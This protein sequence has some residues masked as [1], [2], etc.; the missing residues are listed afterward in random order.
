MTCTSCSY[1]N[2]D[3]SSF[4]M[5]CGAPLPAAQKGAAQEGAA[6]AA[7]P[8]P[9]PRPETLLNPYSD[10]PAAQA[11][12]QPAATAFTPHSYAGFWMRFLAA[13]IDGILMLIATMILLVPLMLIV[14]LAGDAAAIEGVANLFSYFV[15][16][17]LA[18][19]Y[20]ALM[21]SSE[22]Q[23]TVGKLALGLRVTDL[24][25]NRISFGRATG[26]HFAKYLSQIILMIGYLIQPFTERKQA[27]HD[28]L[29]GTVVE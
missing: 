1:N 16:I 17:P 26:R 23:A 10:A 9:P 15:S 29:A 13:V 27:L 24:N 20:E 19:L 25:G 11:A 8:P 4:C 12:S 22:K 21:T 18:W 5:R 7:A 14:G 6:P 3:E 28:I 2:P